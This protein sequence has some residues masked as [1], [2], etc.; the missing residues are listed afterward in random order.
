MKYTRRLAALAL[1]LLLSFVIGATAALAQDNTQDNTQD[2]PAEARVLRVGFPEATLISETD[3]QG[4]HKGQT[5]DFLQEI[6]K[7][8][9]WEYEYVSGDAGELMGMLANGEIDLMGGMYYSEDSAYEYPNYNMGYSY[10]VLYA[11]GDDKTIYSFDSQSLD[12]KVIGVYKP[13]LTKIEQLQKQLDFYNI[14]CEFKYYT[15]QDM[16]DGTLHYHLE[17]GEVD[18]LLGNDVDNDG[19]MR[20]VLRFQSQPYYMVTYKGNTELLE[21]LDRAL[22]YIMDSNPNFAEECYQKN[23]AELGQ[24]TI[25]NLTQEERD[26][27]T[28]T[29]SV[30][31]AVMPQWHPL[32]CSEDGDGHEGI[33]FE[34][35]DQ[36]A[37][38][39]GLHFE[40]VYAESYD[41]IIRM[42]QDGEADLIG[43]FLDNTDAAA[44]DGLALTAAYAAVDDILLKNKAVDYPSEG[45][46]VGVLKGRSLPS[47]IKAAEVR[48]YS[49][50]LEGLKAVNDGK[51]DMFYGFAASVEEDIQTHRLSNLS[52]VALAGSD[53]NIA[54]AMARP[55][56]HQLFTL[57]NKA[58]SSMSQDQKTTLIS[59]NMVSL[60][61]KS[62]WDTLLY[63]DPL[64]LI[65]I[66][67]VFFVLLL[68]V[69]LL[70]T[71]TR[72]KNAEMKSELQ[73]AEAANQAKSAF[74]SRMS[75]EIRTPMNAIVGLADLASM[76]EDISPELTE[77]L[78]KMQSASHYL[79]SL[80]NDILDMSSIEND[81]MILAA[82]SFSLSRVVNELESMMQAQARRKSLRFSVQHK[83]AGDWYIGDALRLK[84]VL[85][86]LLSN[87]VKFTPE[88]GEI[89][90]R[91][92]EQ[93]S[94]PEQATLRFAVKDT[95]VG[96]APEAQEKVFI[97]FEQVGSSISKSEGTGLGLPISSAIV[98]QMGGRLELNSVQGEGSEFFFTIV[99]PTAEEAQPQQLPEETARDTGLA[100]IRILLAEDNDLNAEIAIELL[101]MQGAQVDR[102]ANGQE[103]TE[104][105][106]SSKQG[107]Y[108]LILMDIQMPVKNGLE[109]TA[110]IRQSGHPDAKS[111]PIVAMT[112]NSFKED[113]DTAHAAGMDAFV[114]KPVDI[115][116]LY[117]ILQKLIRK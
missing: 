28:N 72:I 116:Y 5:E 1:I 39:T 16:V 80:I 17:N 99:L 41:E 2:A 13:A 70:I 63:S 95:G 8:T 35:L 97:K 117:E 21:E 62:P 89:S 102:V 22:F 18:L 67:S 77:Y 37:G 49:T 3:S 38:M 84:Q 53:T 32:Y 51:L 66:V 91:I 108:R 20:V 92:D 45:L 34:F 26:Y 56:K 36:V 59:R 48:E 74:L 60:G 4:R 96:I 12:G 109:A 82:E 107:Y 58:I 88:G 111:V 112:A 83:A 73:R 98:E 25:L 15:S 115:K 78:D 71:R 47:T 76:S 68:I 87:A 9:G 29:D 101:Q 106:R 23:V 100:G 85:T 46:A 93:S 31:V 94:T 69:I 90:L 61:Y 44:K 86:N 57:L 42:V 14:N 110:E 10:A 64:V 24:P 54:F 52:V 105:F 33:V 30:K 50:V 81:K 27:I 113:V 43:G 75:H 11:R 114:P 40:Y 7:Y 79:L 19:T 104:R 103:A 55:V 6:A 65:A